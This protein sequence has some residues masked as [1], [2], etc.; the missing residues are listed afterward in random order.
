M[1]R[2]CFSI[3][4]IFSLF[5]LMSCDRPKQETPSA[6]TEARQPAIAEQPAS[7]A[8]EARGA[9]GTVAEILHSGGY[10]YLKL[11]ASGKESWAAI[12]ENKG[13]EQGKTVSL[14]EGMV[15][16]N[17]HSR[18]LDRTFDEILFSSGLAG[19]KDSAVRS[20]HAPQEKPAQQV[21]VPAPSSFQAA[22]SCEG[23]TPVT[24][25][26]PAAESG[27][28]TKAVAAKIAVATPKAPG[29]DGH[30][31]AEIFA[32][33]TQLAGKSVHVQGTVAKVSKNIMGRHWVHIQDGSGD[34]AQQTHDLVGTTMDPPPQQGDT[35]LMRGTVASDRDFG[36]GYRYA[37]L[38]ENATFTVQPPSK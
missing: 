10:T 11:S 38:V 31:V 36:A 22:L 5:F 1:N 24:S 32:N 29:P 30:T 26:G 3:I 7:A 9:Q 18:T 14:M 28:S 19:D 27:G 25:P 16:K 17:F 23:T 15:M 35:V 37:A 33:H 34:P 20:P 13:I 12:P 4:F 6:T 2:A 21:T 8:P